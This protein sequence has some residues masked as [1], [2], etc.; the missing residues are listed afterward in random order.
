MDQYYLSSPYEFFVAS[1]GYFDKMDRQ[2]E[3]ARGIAYTMYCAHTE[4]DKQVTLQEFWPLFKDKF[5]KE[6]ATPSWAATS[7]EMRKQLLGLK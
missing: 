2:S 3:S 1:E 5:I 4:K 7:L 6:D